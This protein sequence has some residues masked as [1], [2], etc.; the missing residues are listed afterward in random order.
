MSAYV[1]PRWRGIEENNFH[2]LPDFGDGGACW[3]ECLA[4]VT[5][6]FDL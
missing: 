2:D 1:K 3:A 4:Q 5:D 6:R